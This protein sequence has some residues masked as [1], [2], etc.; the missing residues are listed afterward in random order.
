MA[1]HTPVFHRLRVADKR[2][3]T[4]DSVVLTFA[5]PEAL[6]DSYRHRHGQ[7]LTLRAAPNGEEIRRSYSVCA[8]AGGPLR[9]GVRHV[10]DGAMS[11]WLA[12]E[13]A[14]GDEIEVMT[15]TGSFTC[16]TDAS[17]ARHHV[18]IAAGSGITPILSIVGTLLETEPDST[19]SLLYVNRSHSSTMFVE[20]LEALKNR[21]LQ[22]L[23][24]TH[25]FT[26]EPGPSALLSG[27]IDRERF[28]ALIAAGVI[29]AGADTYFVCGPQAMAETILG[30][31]AEHGV[32]ADRVRSELFGVPAPARSGPPAGSIVGAECTVVLNG[33]SS[34]VVVGP[35]DTVLDA[36]LRNRSDMPYSCRAGACSTCRARVTSGAVAM[37]VCYGLEPD[38]V[39]AGYVLTCQARPTTDEVTVDYDA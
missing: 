12:D 25:L 11:S 23:R 30:G 37:D 24:I 6:A 1:R 16:G 39:A 26:R 22:R 4:D 34:T 20:E 33:R 13:V 7:H 29:D 35:D 3:D 18:A 8:P 5:I 10:P 21:H 28:D 14:V 36:A 17:T 38:E 15:P 27:R 19:V 32:E 31:L 9:I 2:L